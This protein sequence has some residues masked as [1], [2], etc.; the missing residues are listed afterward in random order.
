MSDKVYY[1]TLAGNGG[2]ND[3]ENIITVNPDGAVAKGKTYKTAQAAIDYPNALT[4][5]EDANMPSKD[6]VWGILITGTNDENLT[7]PHWV[8][9]IG[10]GIGILEGE[11][12][13]APKPS[14]IEG[15]DMAV[16]GVFDD[17]SGDPET[18]DGWTFTPFEPGA[19]IDKE[20]T[21]TYDGNTNSVRYDFAS[22]IGLLSQIYTVE[23]GKTYRCRTYDYGDG[24]RGVLFAD[25]ALFENIYTPVFGWIPSNFMGGDITAPNIDFSNWTDIGGGE[26]T[27]DDFTVVGAL[28]VEREETE[29]YEGTY[30]AKL[31]IPAGMGLLEFPAITAYDDLS[32]IMLGDELPIVMYSKGDSGNTGRLYC[33]VANDSYDSYTKLFDF[34][35]DIWVN[36]VPGEEP[37]ANCIEELNGTTSYNSKHLRP[38]A[39]D[40][41]KIVPIVYGREASDIFYLGKYSISSEGNAE[42]AVFESENL[43]TNAY[44]ANTLFNG[45]FTDWTG[46][47]ADGWTAIN[48]TLTKEEFTIPEGGLYAGK[49]TGTGAG[50]Y[51]IAAPL[52]ES[53]SEGDVV[54]MKLD[55]CRD[56]V[57]GGYLMYGF[58]NN[59]GGSADK[60][61][62]FNNAEWEAWDGS[63]ITYNNLRWLNDFSTSYQTYYSELIQIDSSAKLQPIFYMRNTE[64]TVISYLDNVELQLVTREYE[65]VGNLISESIP[66]PA[67]GEIAL[68]AFPVEYYYDGTRLDID[69]YNYLGKAEFFE[70]TDAVDD[71]MSRQAR[72]ITFKDLKLGTDQILITNN[73]SFKGCAPVGGTLIADGGWIDGCDFSNLE[74]YAHEKIEDVDSSF[75]RTF[76]TNLSGVGSSFAEDI[77]FSDCEFLENEEVKVTFGDGCSFSKSNIAS[78]EFLGDAT[79]YNSEFHGNIAPVFADAYYYMYFTRCKNLN[80]TQGTFNLVN[81]TSN[82][83][84][85]L[86]GSAILNRKN[87]TSCEVEIDPEGESTFNSYGSDFDNTGTTFSSKDDESVIKELGAPDKTLNAVDVESTPYVVISSAQLSHI[88]HTDTAP[89]AVSLQTA[90]LADRQIYWFKDASFNA[91]TN[92][93]TITPTTGTIDGQANWIIN[94]DGGCVGLYKKDGNWFIIAERP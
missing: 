88:L 81:C 4:A 13:V 42:L 37:P 41:L 9:P 52:D 53:Y 47:D 10:L 15:D 26:Y 85:N 18:P 45:D 22:G 40:N 65:W 84:I 23:A 54:R 5:A 48:G 63:T 3:L 49:F 64:G 43:F 17:W 80:L 35:N 90:L 89:V 29:V 58:L 74:G 86:G 55:A 39:E 8:V 44:G 72:D 27:L 78:A 2:T 93:I 92:N 16:N 50:D 77:S 12:Q 59:E 30:A 60:I 75:V 61:W 91:N 82:G 20:T 14:D 11:I 19:T 25:G 76:T 67:S 70:Y 66:A 32:P 62:N 79:F 7:F 56:S 69:V 94:T 71:L 83:V 87:C 28:T 46:S 1:S 68:A 73:C 21:R 57:F 24:R 33:V 31:T 34:E 38:Y 6:N 36:A 51:V